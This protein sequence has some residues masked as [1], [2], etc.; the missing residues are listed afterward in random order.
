ME[1]R[2]RILPPHAAART[3]AAACALLLVACA[4]VGVAGQ[5]P[6]AAPAPGGAFTPSA[7]PAAHYGADPSRSCESTP[8]SQDVQSD[9]AD[10]S[11]QAG[12]PAPEP[13]GRLC[14][15]AQ[16]LLGWDETN[17]PPEAVVSWL[18]FYFG[19]PAAVT[20]VTVATIDSEDAKQI[21]PRLEEAMLPYVRTSTQVRY[22]LATV[23]EEKPRTTRIR[24]EGRTKVSLVMQDALLDLDPLPRK[25]DPAA[26]ATLSGRLRGSLQNPVVLISGPRGNLIQP[27]P[28]PGKEFRVPVSCDGRTG[29]MAVEIRAEDQGSIRLAANFPVTCGIEQPGSVQIPAPPSGDAG[30]QE[31]AAFEQINA[32]RAA[33]GIKPLAWS[34]KAAQVAR[35]VSESAQQ[36]AAPDSPAQ[37]AERLRQAGIASQLVLQNP[38]EARSIEAAQQR[39]SL[40]PVHRANYMSTDATHAGIGVATTTDPKSGTRVVITELFVRELAQLDVSTVAPRLRDAVNKRRSSAGMSAFRDDATLDKVAQEYAASLAESAGNMS[41]GK[42]NHIVAPLYRNFRTVDFLSGAK[43]DPLEFADEKTVITSK[44]RAMG[45]GV[46]QGNHPVLGKNA[47]YVVLLFGT[48]K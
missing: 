27:A 13:D 7:P 18:S 25:L 42:H 39:F 40:S 5:R 4:G 28:K 1:H 21:A 47:T 37:M 32:E 8:T 17:P 15:L 16:T 34:D 33:A 11:K 48:H 20:R 10:Q 31:R 23:R 6:G 38:G 3:V 41:D 30:Q 29:R 44:E 35:A 45:I 43:G 24:E 36:G 46:A 12:K 2:H 26:E 14:A 9:M 22:G 19:I